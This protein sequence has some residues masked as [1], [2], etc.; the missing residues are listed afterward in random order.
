NEWS[1]L[2]AN[3]RLDAHHPPVVWWRLLRVMTTGFSSSFFAQGGWRA[4]TMGWIESIYQGFSMFI[5]YA[6]LW[7][8]QQKQNV[9]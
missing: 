4:G 6:K 8:V 7:E 1:R 3:L 2:E 9:K 5:T